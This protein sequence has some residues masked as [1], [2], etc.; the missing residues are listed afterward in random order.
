MPQLHKHLE[1]RTE[2]RT[3]LER[4]QNNLPSFGSWVDITDRATTEG[5]LSS[6]SQQTEGQLKG[7]EKP[8]RPI[9]PIPNLSTP[10]RVSFGF[11]KGQY[12][13]L[14]VLIHKTKCSTLDANAIQT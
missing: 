7:L 2:T 4:G 14:R 13:F 11:R 3:R 8:P 6:N 9:Y 1:T 10:N 5:Q 12:D